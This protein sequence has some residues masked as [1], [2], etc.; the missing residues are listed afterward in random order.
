[1]DP[2]AAMDRLLEAYTHGDWSVVEELAEGLLKWLH[3]GGFPPRPVFE[4]DGRRVESGGCR[5][6]LSF[7]SVR[8]EN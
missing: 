6:H 8:G 5:V 3:R 4:R 1:M 7:C 2:Q